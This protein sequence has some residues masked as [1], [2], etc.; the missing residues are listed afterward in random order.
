MTMH[1]QPVPKTHGFA[2]GRV[3]WIDMA[4]APLSSACRTGVIRTAKSI[5]RAGRAAG[6]P[7]RT[8]RMPQVSSI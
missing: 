2:A 4:L 7:A 8:I 3:F 6:T 5:A 1:D